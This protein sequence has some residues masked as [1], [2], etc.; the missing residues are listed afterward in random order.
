LLPL[1]I[2]RP[3]SR[4]MSP[5]EKQKQVSA[6][7]LPIPLP[8]GE[9]V[10]RKAKASF[11]TPNKNGVDMEKDLLKLGLLFKEAGFIRETDWQKYMKEMNISQKSMGEVLLQEVSLKTFKDFGEVT[12]KAIKNILLMEIPLPFGRKKEMEVET[13]KPKLENFINLPELYGF[14]EKNP[15]SVKPVYDELIKNKIVSKEFVTNIEKESKKL[16]TTS[17]KIILK[18]QAITPEMVTDCIVADT[19]FQ[20]KCRFFMIQ[21]LLTLNNILSEEDIIVAKNEADKISQPIINILEKQKKYT[22]G[23]LFDAIKEGGIWFQEFALDKYEISDKIVKLLP[24]RYLERTL[25][26]PVQKIKNK[27]I[28]AM[29]NPFD[30]KTI[31]TIAFLIDINVSPILINENDFF[32]LFQKFISEKEEEVKTVIEPV[33]TRIKAPTTPSPEV[34]KGKEVAKP[35]DPSKEE[36]SKPVTKTLE[37][38][39]KP[40]G[41]SM[42]KKLQTVAES[43]SA[44]EVVATV[45]ENA[46]NNRATDVH[47]ESM[48][49]CMRVRLRIDGRLHNIMD[50]NKDIQESVLSRIKILSNMD[51]TERRR[52]QDGHFSFKIGNKNY[53]MRIATIPTFWGEKLVMRIFSEATILKG[54]NELGLEEDDHEKINA[55][56]RFTNG[57]LLVTGPTGSGKTST[58]YSALTTLNEEHRN[59]V[60]IEDPIE[61]RIRGINQIQVDTGIDLTFAN[62]IRAVLRQD[63]NVLMV[64]EIRDPDTAYIA[65]RAA[66]TGHLVLSTLHTGS[67]VSALTTLQYMG[68]EP[69]MIASTLVGV[70]AQR[71]VR[72][73]CPYCEE[74]YKPSKAI[75]DELKIAQTETKKIKRG[76]GC[77]K[78]FNTG[79]FGRTGVFEILTVSNILRKMVVESASEQDIKNVALG[80]GLKTL[81]LG[82]REKVLK[83]I[84]SPEEV[85]NIVHI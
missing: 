35:V 43:G 56:I 14:F 65:T 4:R 6:T 80:E 50:L 32:V 11:R 68:I 84:T 57:M 23:E 31:D 82:G 59:I 25:S 34:K 33:K 73:I 55:L 28:L 20:K 63:A 42:D 29:V 19:E 7:P 67:A 79:F 81:F 62:C 46:I 54:F 58:L 36:I 8:Q 47:F 27:L 24:V 66:L 51:V 37:V 38:K 53:D 83:G 1:L 69:F 76:K 52:P 48:E 22:Q 10:I 71:L 77:E 18:K 16:K 13:E 85:L 39:E 9:R 41:V 61:Y 21:E 60:S 64:G 45:V 2:A 74:S 17:D 12:T 15:K 49:D 75:L 70:I 26:F 44:V 30:I 5:E 40:I 78:C 3:W 72:K